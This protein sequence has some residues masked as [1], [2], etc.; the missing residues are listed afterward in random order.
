MMKIGIAGP[1][2]KDTVIWE[3]GES[4]S[5]F[6]AVVYSTTALAK[7]F[8][9]SKDEVVCLSHVA[10][11][12]LAEI[13]RLLTHPNIKL[14][15]ISH[16]VDGT[17]IVLMYVDQHERVSKQTRIMTPLSSQE[18][19]LL[20]DCDF[21]ILMP[22]NE[23]DIGLEQLRRLRE[24]SSATIFLD[25]HG[26]ITGVD[27]RGRRYKKNWEQANEWLR[28][29]D[30]LKMNEREASLAA[31]RI[32]DGFNDYLQF[33]IEIVKKDVNVVWITFGDQSSLIVWQRNRKLYWGT[34]PVTNAGEVVDTIGCG[35]TA[36]AGFAYAYERLHSPLM[37]V[38]MGNLL[39]SMKA[40]TYDVSD[41]PTRPEV[42]SMI[43]EHYREYLHRL[44]DEFLSQKH[45]IVHEIKEENTNESLMYST[46]GD[47][48]NYGTDYESSS[49]SQGASAPRT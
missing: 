9:E 44:L 12:D 17:E 16:N 18:I 25:I 2:S 39:G 37:A 20:A 7:L 10:E 36:S 23:T 15:L 5:K 48:Y 26:L 4:L 40:T 34:V 27:E 49:H 31:G 24:Q 43:Y 22:L 46:N 42:R 41:F 30:I 6:G 21:V 45:L 13:N 32:F 38:V 8:E 3:N 33:A 28:L 19:S 47:R 35:D 11:N 14:N 29:I 1:L